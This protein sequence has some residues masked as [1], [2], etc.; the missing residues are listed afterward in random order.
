MVIGTRVPSS[1]T[2][3]DAS[4]A[5]GDRVM[6]AAQVLVPVQLRMAPVPPDPCWNV[7]PVPPLAGLSPAVEA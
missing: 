5:L 2:P 3:I 7:V 4:P 1:S 6:V